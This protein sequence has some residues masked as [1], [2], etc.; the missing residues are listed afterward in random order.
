[1]W[2]GMPYGY[3][4]GDGWMH[5]GGYWL[6]MGL[7]GLFWLLLVAAIVVGIIWAVR[8]SGR[9]YESAARKAGSSARE[10]LDERYARGDI[11]R[12]EYL[13]RRKDLEG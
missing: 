10:V 4:Y 8:A 9:P 7:H 12:E 1:M 3:G 5:G 2:Q 11:D 13:A 6:G